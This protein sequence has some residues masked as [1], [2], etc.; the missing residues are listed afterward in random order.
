M[1]NLFGQISINFPEIWRE[2]FESFCQSTT[3]GAREKPDKNPFPRNVDMWFLAIC[4]AVHLKIEPDFSDKGKLYKPIPGTVF[5]SELWRSDSLIMLA[6]A[7][8]G[9]EKIIDNPNEMMK[10]ANGYAIAGL[11]ILLAKLEEGKGDSSLDYLS[12]YVIE[13]I[14]E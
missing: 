4:I 3:A 10:I 7:H 12:D 11:P 2:H 9:D 8:S 13:L 14:E 6:I 1:Q 5:G